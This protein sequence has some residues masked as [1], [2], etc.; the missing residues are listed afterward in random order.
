MTEIQNFSFKND[1]IIGCPEKCPREKC[2]PEISPPRKLPLENY[3]PEKCP[4]ENCPQEKRTPGK[5]P[6]P[7]KNCSPPLG[8]SFY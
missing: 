5:M 4:Q 1:A 8:K 3:P 7:P 2:T 6:S